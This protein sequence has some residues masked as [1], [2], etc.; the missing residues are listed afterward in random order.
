MGNVESTFWVYTKKGPVFAVWALKN[1]ALQIQ[2]SL[3]IRDI[4]VRNASQISACRKCPGQAECLESVWTEGDRF[5]DQVGN[6][7]ATSI[8]QCPVCFGT[9]LY[10]PQ[11]DDSTLVSVNCPRVHK[12]TMKWCGDCL[13][14]EG[15]FHLVSTSQVTCKKDLQ[16]GI[17]LDLLQAQFLSD[18]DFRFPFLSICDFYSDGLRLRLAQSLYLCGR[19][20]PELIVRL[21]LQYL[22][23]Q[24]YFQALWLATP[25]LERQFIFSVWCGFFRTLP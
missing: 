18:L 9:F 5:G 8:Q 2:D 1:T 16:V 19:D 21:L 20:S 3:S 6:R 15:E 11:S 24:R 10:F 4:N 17:D 7:L 14:S 12:E 22:C 23:T 13:D 25:V